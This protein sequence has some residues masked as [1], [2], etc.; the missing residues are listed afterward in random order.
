MFE[1][2]LLDCKAYREWILQES[3][4]PRGILRH[5]SFV[6]PTKNPDDGWTPRP[7]NM[8][9]DYGETLYWLEEGKVHHGK[10]R[11]RVSDDN[12]VHI[13]ARFD[14]PIAL[15]DLLIR[16]DESERN[17]HYNCYD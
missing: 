3:Q 12:Q 4:V 5:T 2:C 16:T 17:H 10:L 11:E 13:H 7:T 1:G 15:E 14:R 6:A 9:P 8:L